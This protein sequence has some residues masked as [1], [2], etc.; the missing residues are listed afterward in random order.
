MF[1]IKL[2]VPAMA[3]GLLFAAG[4]AKAVDIGFAMHT[5]P[6]GPEFEAVNKFAELVK[7]RSKGHF[8]VKIF[9]SAVL[10]GERDN[11]EQ[12]TVNEVQMTLFG[13]TLPNVVAPPYAATVVPFVFPNPE[14]IFK[15]WAGPVGAEGKKLI[16]DKAKLDV[17]AFFRRGDRHLS[18]KKVIRSPDDLKGLKLRVPEIPSWVRVWKELGASPTPVAW[19][20]VFSGLQMGVIEAQENP[21]FNVNQAKLFEVQSHLMFTAHVPAVWHW[22]VS[23][24]FLD[25]LRPELREA[26]LSS[27]VDAAKHG[28]EVTKQQ[29]DGVCK[30]LATKNKMTLVEVDRGPF[31]AKARPAIEEIAKGWAP[32]VRE[33]VAQYLK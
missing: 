2:A 17:I 29:I 30:D 33:A 7:E 22:T 23:S 10:G 26:V 24:R 16:K 9:H 14:E 1:R 27:I 5:S 20:E 15:F 12:L 31:I 25:G 4:Q 13:D 28:D 21:C 18:A 19:P 11:L 3:L 32:S 6:P 8:N